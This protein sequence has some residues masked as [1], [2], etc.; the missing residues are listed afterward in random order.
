[1]NDE[2]GQQGRCQLVDVDGTPMRVQWAGELTE[3]DIAALRELREACIR[4]YERD[5]PEAA[6][7]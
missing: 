7:A 6:G 1:M 3:T 4:L 2:R 5:H